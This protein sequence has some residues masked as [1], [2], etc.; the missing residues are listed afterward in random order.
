MKCLHSR[1]LS[2]CEGVV[3]KCVSVGL[4]A[5]IKEFLV[6]L[7]FLCSPLWHGYCKFL[8]NRHVIQQLRCAGLYYFQ[9][10]EGRSNERQ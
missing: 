7:L 1:G 10:R 9:N 8:F 2:V 3:G 5:A 4:V 6:S